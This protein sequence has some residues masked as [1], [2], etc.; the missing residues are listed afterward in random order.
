MQFSHLRLEN[1]R[2]FSTVDVALQTRVFIVGANAAGKSNLLDVFRFLRDVVT[3]GGGFQKAVTSRGGVSIIRNLAA[4]NRT[5]VVIDVDLSEGEAILWRYRIVFNQDNRSRPILR[6]E[7]I[8]QGEKLLVDRPDADDNADEARLSQTYLEQTFANKDFR[9]VTD[10]FKS[11]AYSHIV[12]QLIRDPERSISRQADPYGGD[13]LEQIAVSNQRTQEARLRRIQ[14]A[15][16][17][18]VPQLSELELTR[19]ET[20]IPHLRGKY[21]HWR[22]K[23]AWQQETE[24]SDGTLRLIGLLWALQDGTGPLLLEEPELSL[25]PGVVR[26]L[27][28]MMQRLR[29]QMKTAP[30][31]LFIST[32]SSELLSDEGIA[33]DEVLLLLTSQE[34]TEVKISASLPDVQQELDAGLTIAQAVL[35]R[36]EPPNL[37]QLSLFGE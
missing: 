4:R 19:D 26:Q 5:D 29:R 31:Q 21:Q 37:Q 20:G 25:H 13:F 33:P 2:N 18:A 7:K 34:G 30:R 8:W 3:P 11:I 12:P 17:I 23:G 10:F 36:T 24:F 35:A 15:L 9:D 14:D 28:Q 32:H 16:K 6:E 27:P 22:P 1:W